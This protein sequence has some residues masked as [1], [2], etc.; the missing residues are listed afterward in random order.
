MPTSSYEKVR[1]EKYSLGDPMRC[2]SDMTVASSP[3]L[4]IEAAGQLRKDDFSFVKQR[5]GSYTYARLIDCSEERLT[6]DGCKKGSTKKISRNHWSEIIQLV[7]PEVYNA[8][9]PI[10]LFISKVPGDDGDCSM[11]SDA[12]FMKY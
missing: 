1:E 8:R 9:P 11:I 7:A 3:D 6:F 2:L 12:F 4:A 10:P 5:N